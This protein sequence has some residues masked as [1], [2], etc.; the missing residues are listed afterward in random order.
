[1]KTYQDLVNLQDN[2][3]ARMKFVEEAVREHKVSADYKIAVDAN[4][5]DKKQ[6]A[7]IKVRQGGTPNGKHYGSGRA[8]RH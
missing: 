3:A 8:H 1:M 5:Y 4:T 7:T 2:E 6:N